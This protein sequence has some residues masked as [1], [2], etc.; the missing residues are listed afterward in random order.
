MEVILLAGEKSSRGT[1]WRW[2]H[3]R[4]SH[5]ILLILLLTTPISSFS[6]G[7]G[8]DPIAKA[9]KQI[10]DREKNEAMKTLADALRED[11]DKLD[12]IEEQMRKIR[13]IQKVFN[14]KYEELLKV[15]YEEKDVEKALKIIDELLV[16]DPNPNKATLEAIERARRGA[17]VVANQ[18]RFNRIMD[19]ALALLKKEEFYQAAKTYLPGFELHRDEFNQA[20]YGQ[21]IVTAVNNVVKKVFETVQR[22]EG[23]KAGHI[24]DRDA[25]TKSIQEAQSKEI[26]SRLESFFANVESLEE[27]RDILQEAARVLASNSQLIRETRSDKSEDYF[28]FYARALLEGRRDRSER[29]GIINSVVLL[30]EREYAAR[31]DLLAKE[32]QLRF[33]EAKRQ[34]N[35]NTYART[36]A[37]MEE[38]RSYFRALMDLVYRRDA[39]QRLEE[40][41]EV[42][43]NEGI[44]IRSKL[45]DF[46]RY[47]ERLRETLAYETIVDQSSGIVTLDAVT[48]SPNLS[49]RES[50]RKTVES[51]TGV[52][53]SLALEWSQYAVLLSDVDTV[54]ADAADS[55]V[56][57]IVGIT[58]TYLASYRRVL[59]LVL[60][61]ADS[62]FNV[63]REKL[64]NGEVV[65]VIRKDESGVESQEERVVKYPDE[66][67]ENLKG[68]KAD[69]NGLDGDLNQILT[70]WE[71]K[72]ETILQSP[73]VS[74]VLNDV[75][76]MIS[77]EQDLLSKIEGLI[78]RANQD[79]ILAQRYT[80][81]GKERYA[82]A[83]AG[84]NRKE[85]E[86]ARID[87]RL[88]TEALDKSLEHREDPEVRNLRDVIFPDFLARINQAENALVVAEVRR[89]ID[90]AVGQYR[91]G[92]FGEAENLLVRAQNRWRDTNATDNEEVLDWLT[93]VRRAMN[94][95]KGWEIVITDPL[96]AEITQ[97]LKFA[98]EDYNRGVRLLDEGKEQEVRESFDSAMKTLATIRIPFP[99]LK[100]ANT[101]QLKITRILEPDKFREKFNKDKQEARQKL[102]SSSRPELLETYSQLKEYEQV[103]PKDRDLA[104]L[105]TEFE[106][107][108]DLKIRPPTQAEI[109]KSRQNYQS[110]KSIYDKRQRDLYDRAVELLNDAI[111][112]WPDNREAVLLKDRILI[113]TGGARQDIIS[114]DDSK[115]LET[116][117]K[118][119]N[120]RNYAE[121]YRIV[122]VLLK[123][124]NNQNYPRLLDLEEKLKRRLGIQ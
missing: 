49:A 66:R 86:D 122:Q 5:L 93:L 44:I 57:L 60:A 87:I 75:R 55:V 73:E 7:E 117:E 62:Q 123:N 56:S 45:L 43:S 41:Y 71:S 107:A 96:Y 88:A 98:T 37:L 91:N 35:Q 17:L 24:S 79:I 54:S 14:E 109:A 120:E 32:A 110:A 59:D 121:S 114:S 108:L 23:A 81:E 40:G 95:T 77:V 6:S 82:A 31:E 28:L 83:Q 1:G 112:L 52:L 2:F 9:E 72:G 92:D 89:L 53:D 80:R 70:R 113:A 51:S 69:I 50:L 74:Q 105:I 19:E 29:E 90:Q 47:Q 18:N 15:L 46:V 67:L 11:A 30:L 99:L 116:A 33:E 38:A 22:F 4:W 102:R 12:A 10:E 13:E 100:A 103:E 48:E 3:P 42:G 58:N 101:L 36:K 8:E 104:G 21:I 76:T 94:L 25:F 64:L 68:L 26:P 39:G 16:L 27:M 106:Y 119:F 61:Q 111:K 124:P 34:Y 97:L 63:E 118:L 65:K 85:F 115:K 20:E 78:S 84:F